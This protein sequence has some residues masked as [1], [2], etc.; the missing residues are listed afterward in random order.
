MTPE[1]DEIYSDV[2]EENGSEVIMMILAVT[3]RVLRTRLAVETLAF[4]VR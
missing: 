2:N 4:I 1:T 3:K